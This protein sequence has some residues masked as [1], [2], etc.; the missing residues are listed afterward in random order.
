[1]NET[2]DKQEQ[3]MK[4]IASE[5]SLNMKQIKNVISMINEGNTV[6]FI[7]RYRKEQT[8]ALDEVQIRNV[9]ERWQ[10]IQNLEQR[11]EEVIRLIDEQGKLTG[12]LKTNIEKSVKLQEVED[13]Y[14]PYK[15]KR[16]TKATVAKEKG[17]EPLAEWIL[18]LPLQGSIEAEAS[19][20]L[21][22]E[23]GVTTVEEAIAG[24]QDIIAEM[25]SDDA[26]SRK[27]IRTETSKRGLIESEV[28]DR[29]KDEKDVYEMY[30]GYAEPI[31]KIVP[32]RILALNRGEK[33][34]I[35]RVSV[36]VETDS[37]L[38]YLNRKWITN[39]K[40]L[41]ATTI[42]EAVNDAYKRLIQPSIEREIRGE[43]TEKA[44]EQAIH[45]FSENLRKLLLQPPLKGKMVL[46]LTL[47]IVQ[48]VNW[49]WSMKRARF[50]RS[51]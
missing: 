37:V 30:Y 13:L 18:S 47:P 24:A 11:K 44:E 3:Y 8:G 21:S 51:M 15:Q 31:S 23:K 28:K 2:I 36:K 40:S 16:R 1:M 50:C 33:E 27:W 49:H 45:I 38:N 7:A 20:Y 43:L 19:K 22:D 10:Y 12:E 42:E 6:P 32:H 26:S 46:G 29:D 17:L 4:L 9:I 5:Q 25:F 41:T 14:R 39:T 34:G 48:V 35:L